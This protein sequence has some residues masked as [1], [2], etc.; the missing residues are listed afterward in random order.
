M[1]RASFLLI[2]CSIFAAPPVYCQ[3]KSPESTSATN[4]ADLQ[5][6]LLEEDDPPQATGPAPIAPKDGASEPDSAKAQV[7]VAGSLVAAGAQAAAA[8]AQT[9]AAG[10]QAV[11]QKAQA[12]AAKPQ[13][14]AAKLAI[15]DAL[16]RGDMPAAER[17]FMDAL[18]RFPNDPDLREVRNQQTLRLHDEK[19]RGIFDRTLTDSRKLFGRQWL[20]GESMDEG[21]WSIELEKERVAGARP[22]KPA[23]GARAALANGYALL[24]RGDPVRAE[25]VLSGAI[26]KNS[27]SAPLY[28]ARVMARGM[29]GN[30]KGADED[31]LKAVALSHEQSATLSQ[32]A[33]LMMQSRRRDEA[34]AW[35]DRALKSD[36]GDADALA[37]R[38]RFNW[39]DRGRYDLALEDLKQAARISP[40]RYGSLYQEA[41]KRF[42][43][44]RARSGLAKGDDKQALEDANRALESNAGDA[45]AHMVRGA[46]FSRAGKVEEAI[47][48]TTLA[49][50]ADPRSSDALLY[51]GISMETLGQRGRALA[52][53]KRAAEIDPV[54]F[55]RFY[56]ALIQAQREG[57]PPLWSRKGG[58]VTASN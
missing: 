30:L 22:L 56:E 43:G 34:F 28:Y 10:P 38:G 14:V 48:E 8:S 21:E 52:D 42:Y 2:S 24:D 13:A 32:R 49:I 11:V 4:S 29:T 41:Q 27:D 40:E 9:A 37:I 17:L 31:S 12:A 54:R 5:G 58:A 15:R 57:S 35:A 44:Q 55:R 36:S 19:I 53:I 23:S 50:K 3:E 51:R 45:T 26:R 39:S 46:V 7:S 18:D 16:T 47:K 20:P 1:V 33:L 25:Q 6:G